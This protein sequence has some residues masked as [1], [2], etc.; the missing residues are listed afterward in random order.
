MRSNLFSFEQYELLMDFFKQKK[1]EIQ[2]CEID[3]LFKK[4]LTHSIEILELIVR[5]NIG[6][7][8]KLDVSF[9]LKTFEEADKTID[10]L[11]EDLKTLWLTRNKYSRLDKSVEELIKVREFIKRSISYYQGGKDET[12]D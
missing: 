10:K 1:K 12:K 8:E 5:V 9:R 11:I 4:E 2:L 7:Q 6:Y 3:E